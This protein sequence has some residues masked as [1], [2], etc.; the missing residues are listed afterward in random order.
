MSCPASRCQRDHRVVERAVP[1]RDR[2]RRVRP[3][4]SMSRRPSATRTSL[5]CTM[6]A[7]PSLIV[8]RYW[9]S[10]STNARGVERVRV[11]AAVARRDHELGMRLARRGSSR[12]TPRSRA[13]SSPGAG[14]RTTTRC[15]ATRPSTRRGSSR[16]ARGTR[17]SGG[18]SSSKLI[19]AHPPHI[20]HRTGTRSM[21]PGCRLCS[22]NVFLRGTNGVAAVDA[23]A[24]AVERAGEPALARAAARDDAHAAV[25]ARVLE[26]AHA[27]VVGAHHDRPTGRGSRTRRSRAVAGSPRAGTPSAR[28]AA[29]AARL[30]SGRSPGRSSAPSG[31]GR[32]TSIAYG[33]GSADRC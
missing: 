8:R 13:S 21:S 17:R 5:A 30:P 18:A 24:P 32:A 28:P 31:R 26:R 23:V 33:T 19:H 6:P 27:H 4:S 14:T 11:A 29:T 9:M 16:P 1:R 22:A 12:R 10:A 3:G 20:S 25:A 7:M 2:G 15:A